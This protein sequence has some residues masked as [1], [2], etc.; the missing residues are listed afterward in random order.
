MRIETE[1][2][3]EAGG[4][5]LPVSRGRAGAGRA[6]PGQ[7]PHRPHRVRRRMTGTQPGRARDFADRQSGLMGGG[8][9]PNPFGLS[10]AKAEGGGP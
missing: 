1:I 2:A 5:V 6:R 3:D 4:A 8:D 7:A 9:G 10:V